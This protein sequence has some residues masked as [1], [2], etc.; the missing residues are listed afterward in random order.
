MSNVS[1]LDAF[2]EMMTKAIPSSVR[3]G[4]ANRLNEI[5]AELVAEIKL[6]AP[7][8]SGALRNSVRYEVLEKSGNFELKIYVGDDVAF[9]AGF[10]EF[11]TADS[12]AHPFVRPVVYSKKREVGNK[13]ELSLVDSLSRHVGVDNSNVRGAQV[14]GG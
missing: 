5:G 12:P 7:V 3:H 2:R 6:F 13:I 8:D 10:V 14:G 4:L 1:G 9:Y 11:G